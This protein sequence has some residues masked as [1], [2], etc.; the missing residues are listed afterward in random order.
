MGRFMDSGLVLNGFYVATL[1]TPV[2]STPYL[3]QS[4]KHIRIILNH[5]QLTA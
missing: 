4:Q 2:A 3:S 1:F 5:G